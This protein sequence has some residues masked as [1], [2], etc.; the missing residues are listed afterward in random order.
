MRKLLFLVT[1]VLLCS[2]GGGMTPEELA[3]VGDWKVVRE[4][5]VIPSLPGYD[6]TY[7]D[8]T[9]CHLLLTDHQVGDQTYESIVGL[10]C[11][12]NQ[13]TWSLTGTNILHVTEGWTT[14]ILYQ[15]TDSMVL[16]YYVNPTDITYYL[17]K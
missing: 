8:F 14:T 6:T 5:A 15:D 3:L 1:L 2:C 10:H 9:V 4:T 12:P 11:N 13:G 7:T 16:R 17:K